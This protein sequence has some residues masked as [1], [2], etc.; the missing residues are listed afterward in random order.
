VSEVRVNGRRA[1][2]RQHTDQELSIDPRPKLKKGRLFVVS[3]EYAGTAEPVVDPD[4][5]IE[6]WIPTDDGAFV[7]NEPQGSP[8]WYAVN[9]TPRDKATYDIEVTV[10]EGR[11]VM[12][13]GSSCRAVSG[14]AR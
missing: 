14:A 6:G 1:S 11:V 12:S 5:S 10:P 8:G 7:V 2:F 4:G 9:D 13:T 3:V